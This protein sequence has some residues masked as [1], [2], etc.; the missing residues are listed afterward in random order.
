MELA[1]QV[2]SVSQL[3]FCHLSVMQYANLRITLQLDAGFFSGFCLGFTLPN[4]EPSKQK[5]PINL[6]NI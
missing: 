1:L 4:H 6:G 3:Q 2:T 5:S